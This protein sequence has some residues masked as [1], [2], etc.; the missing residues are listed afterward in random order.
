MAEHR[1]A[2]LGHAM[3]FALLDLEVVQLTN[4]SEH[5]GHHDHTL[6][7][8]SHDEDIGGSF[9]GLLACTD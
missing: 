9:G 6:T 1:A 3:H 8:N 5:L 2:A 4:A 7:T